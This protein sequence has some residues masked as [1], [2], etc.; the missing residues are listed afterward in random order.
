MRRVFFLRI[1]VERE[2]AE[3]IAVSLADERCEALLSSARQ[4]GQV[5]RND[6][7]ASFNRA[8]GRGDILTRSIGATFAVPLQTA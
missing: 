2:R 6:L 7:C 3:M 8:G 1:I 5:S 4:S